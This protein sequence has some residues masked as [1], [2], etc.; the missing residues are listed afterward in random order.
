MSRLRVRH[1]RRA[2]HDIGQIAEWIAESSGS[3]DTALD[4]LD[5]FDRRCQQIALAP[6]TGT[7]RTDLASGLR[8]SSFGKYLIFFRAT[9][10][11]LRVVRVIHGARDLRGGIDFD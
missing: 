11:L 2:K 10:R 5:N 7:L 1:A 3:A 8:S 9:K 4:W 6:G